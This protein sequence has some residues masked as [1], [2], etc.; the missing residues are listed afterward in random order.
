MDDHRLNADRQH[1][2]TGRAPGMMTD[3]EPWVG[4]AAPLLAHAG[5]HC[6]DGSDIKPVEAGAEADRSTALSLEDAA[7]RLRAMG[8][9]AAWARTVCGLVRCACTPV[10]RYP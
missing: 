4:E 1:A 8:R 6:G 7:D 9:D 10:T 3:P 2:V 5:P